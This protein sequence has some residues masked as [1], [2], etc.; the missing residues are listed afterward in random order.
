MFD[1]KQNIKQMNLRWASQEMYF[2]CGCQ[3]HTLHVTWRVCEPNQMWLE[4]VYFFPHGTRQTRENTFKA[5]Q[6]MG[7]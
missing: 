4:F 7:P 6:P 5:G 1:Q 3:C 2:N